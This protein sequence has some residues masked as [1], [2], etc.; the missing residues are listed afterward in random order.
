MFARP[1]LYKLLLR[2]IPPERISMNKRILQV[3]EVDNKVRIECSDNT[4]FEGDI[5]VGADG[6]YSAVR[7]NIYRDMTKE[8]ILP[9]EDGENLKAAY[10]CMVG[11]TNRLETDRYPQ[12]KDDFVHFATVQG[13][14]N[15]TVRVFCSQKKQTCFHCCNQQVE[16]ATQQASAISSPAVV[17]VEYT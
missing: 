14:A 9:K 3:K 7:Q 4:Y 11:V 2:Q 10:T 17:R 8:G 15:Y 16:S 13:G 1:E 6:V 5:L 12:L